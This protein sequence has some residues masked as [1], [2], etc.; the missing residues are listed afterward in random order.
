MTPLFPDDGA[1]LDSDVGI[2]SSPNVVLFF[3]ANVYFE[4]WTDADNIWMLSRRHGEDWWCAYR[5]GEFQFGC[6]LVEDAA[7]TIEA[8]LSMAQCWQTSN[9]RYRLVPTAQS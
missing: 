2:E 6:Q 7:R 8:T 4:F 5:R 1:C 9:H 3:G